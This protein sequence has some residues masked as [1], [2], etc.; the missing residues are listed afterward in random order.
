MVREHQQTTPDR[1]VLDL[2]RV[3]VAATFDVGLPDHSRCGCCCIG[4]RVCAM[5]WRHWWSNSWC[6]DGQPMSVGAL[7]QARAEAGVHAHR[8]ADDLVGRIVGDCCVHFLAWVRWRGGRVVGLGLPSVNR[9]QQQGKQASRT[10]SFTKCT[11]SS[12][13]KFLWALRAGPVPVGSTE[14]EARYKC[15]SVELCVHFVKLCVRLACLPCGSPVPQLLLW[16]GVMTAAMLAVLLGLGTWQVERL[17]WKQDML[18]Q[19]ARAEAAPAVPLPDDAGA[20]RQ[21]A[22]DRA[23]ARRSVRLLRRRGARYAGGHSAWH[24]TD[25]AVGAR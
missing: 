2:G 1:P 14:R 24:A 3:P 5:A 17:H 23:P 22:G 19:I 13:E 25:R 11:Q 15:F 18:A 9:Q 6:T 21:G 16:P 10:Q 7:E 20:L 12:T 8:Q 4:P